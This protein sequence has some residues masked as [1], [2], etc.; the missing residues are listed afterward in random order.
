MAIPGEQIEK[1]A[2]LHGIRMTF[3]KM[4][5]P[6]EQEETFLLDLPDSGMDSLLHEAELLARST[7]SYRET[8]AS[9]IPLTHLESIFNVFGIESQT[10]TVFEAEIMDEE[11]Y[12]YPKDKSTVDIGV[13]L[14][15]IQQHFCKWLEEKHPK[16]RSLSEFADMAET[17]FTYVP[18]GT[19]EEKLSD[20]SLYDLSKLT[21]AYAVCIYQYLQ[22]DGH[23]G[24]SCPSSTEFLSMRQQES[25]LLVSGDISGIQQFIYTIPSK[26]ALKSLR[27]RS[28]YLEILLENVVDEILMEADVSRNCL[29]Y[30]GGGHF[31][32]L[33]SNTSKSVDILQ[34][35]AKQVNG[36]FLKHFGSRLYL[37]MAWT[38]CKPAEFIGETENGAGEPFRRV[39]ELLS[40]Q[41]LCRYS[42]EQLADMFTPD[43][44]C[45]K[46]QDGTR[47]CGI[48]HTSSR[49]LAPYGDTDDDTL[50]CQSCR[51][52]YHLGQRMLDC[53]TFLV[54]SQ[55]GVEALPIPGGN[56]GRF[57][58]LCKSNEIA[59]QNVP[60]IRIYQKNRL[61]SRDA[62]SC[63]LWLADYTARN[64][65][66][67]MEFSDLAMCSGGQRDSKGIRRLGV[68]RADV[69]N[70]GAAFIAGF[71]RQMATLS[72]TATLS[73]Q[74]SLFFKRYIQ[75]LCSGKFD[76]YS[77]NTKFSLFGNEKKAERDVHIVYSGGDD[78]FLVGAWDDLIELAVD[79][80]RAFGKFTNDKLTFSAG[81]GF[82]PDKYPVSELARKTGELEDAAKSNP[83]KDSI[84]LFG[85]S[86]EIQSRSK[87]TEKPASYSWE[88]FIDRVCGQK[89][90]FLREQ[91][92]FENSIPQQQTEKKDANQTKEHE[93]PL[94][95]GK[96]G[97]YRILSLLSDAQDGEQSINLARF[98]YVLARLNP[99]EDKA[100]YKAYQEIRQ[101]LYLWYCNPQDRKELRTAIELVIY[102]L[103]DK[104]EK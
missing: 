40:K 103:R 85:A 7:N 9:D 50:A 18:S 5:L 2:L 28:F 43:S 71:P 74:L 23:E 84:A 61:L 30:T 41:K 53:D 51:N 59:S 102:S 58:Y 81:I 83:G 21:A 31:Y 97:L 6:S 79:I 25:L 67:I 100:S 99:G 55:D 10:K 11:K 49:Q 39:S 57:L 4:G 95:I 62:K 34:N 101:K 72:R 104:E 68:M 75:P 93:K 20:I 98:A 48:C 94:L 37:A 78:M 24:Y 26:G 86:T 96:N 8:I 15:A 66:Q 12:P 22:D 38:P 76:C 33:L 47:E 36:W 89:L 87:E 54:S 3:H 19:S 60:L 70:L 1:A 88:T 65:G 64:R 16:N 77:E 73:R 69:D 42:E 63:N 90:A 46:T 45:N 92:E 32:L 56:H 13:Q 80:R 27:G 44:Y 35:F 82:F 17:M 52:L 14:E 91:F 29:L